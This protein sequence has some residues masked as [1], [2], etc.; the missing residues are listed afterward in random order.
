MSQLSIP[1]KDS[2]R[3]PKRQERKPRPADSFKSLP[4]SEEQ[5]TWAIGYNLQWVLS[6]VQ[7]Q[8]EGSARSAQ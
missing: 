1:L 7:T 5:L 6:I 3:T 8:P 2:R 4:L